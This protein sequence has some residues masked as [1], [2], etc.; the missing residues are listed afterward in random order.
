MYVCMNKVFIQC[1]LTAEIVM[2][3]FRRLNQT[4]EFLAGYR[5][6]STSVQNVEVWLTVPE[7]GGTCSKA[8][9]AISYSTSRRDLQ[10]TVSR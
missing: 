3:H 9:R 5:T 10:V 8:A 6:V 7:L 1:A 2:K 4:G